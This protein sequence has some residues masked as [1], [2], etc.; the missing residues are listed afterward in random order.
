MAESPETDPET[1][2]PLEYLEDVLGN[3]G[4]RRNLGRSPS[5]D[6]RA[7]ARSGKAPIP[8]GRNDE[9]LYAEAC[10][11]F[12]LGLL[13]DD[14]L[15]HLRGMP[16]EQ[17]PADPYDED[18]FHRIASS[19]SK[20][21]VSPRAPVVDDR[22][23]TMPIGTPPSWVPRPAKF[24]DQERPVPTI[25]EVAEDLYLFY[26]GMLNGIIGPSETFKTWLACHIIIEE[27]RV[28]GTVLYFDFE[29]TPIISRLKEMGAT[30]ELLESFSYCQPE[31]QLPSSQEDRRRVIA[32]LVTGAALVIVDGLTEAMALEGQDIISNSGAAFYENEVLKPM[33]A[34][35]DVTVIYI[36]HTPHVAPRALGAQHFKSMVTGSSVLTEVNDAGTLV[37][38]SVNKDRHGGLTEAVVRRRSF[39]NLALEKDAVGVLHFQTKLIERTNSGQFVPTERI[40]EVVHWVARF[41]AEHN[42]G[43]SMNRIALGVGG[44]RATTIRAVRMAAKKGRLV[45]QEGVHHN[46]YE[47]VD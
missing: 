18:D 5:A 17:D 4:G 12:G 23:Q 8:K 32:A 45:L 14:V 21:R 19:A 13:H 46:T 15:T 20:Y 36:H 30:D 11:M 37:Y 28:G 47:A 42:E 29:C 41:M 6:I 43:P 9:A 10:R 39:A 7:N 27:L 31:D 34:S 3:D 40:D 25:G 22:G 1:G 2:L 35:G 38:L 24:W 16:L 44:R 26:R 33:T